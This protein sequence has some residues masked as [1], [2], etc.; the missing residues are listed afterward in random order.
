ML[1]SEHGLTERG[2][3]LLYLRYDGPDACPQG[4]KEADGEEYGSAAAAVGQQNSAPSP[5][6]D[7]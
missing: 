1:G 7:A 6:Y 4:Y 2:E 3:Q 5:Q